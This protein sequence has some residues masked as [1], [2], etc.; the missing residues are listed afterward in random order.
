MIYAEFITK[1]LTI[2]IF[3]LRWNSRRKE[4]DKVHCSYVSCSGGYSE[5]HSQRFCFLIFEILQATFFEK[6]HM[7]VLVKDAP[8]TEVFQT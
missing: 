5:N 1:I 6:E 4:V 2:L 8:E 7:H 3:Q